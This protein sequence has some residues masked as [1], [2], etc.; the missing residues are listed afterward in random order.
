MKTEFINYRGKEFSDEKILAKLPEDLRVLLQMING[1]IAF[2]GGLHVRGIIDFPEWHSLQKVW[3][4]DFAL[5]KIFL[6]LKESDI[7]F[8]QDCFGDQFILR[9]GTVWQLNA[10]TDELENM[11]FSLNEF[12]ANAEENPV[13][14]LSLQPLV[15]F[16]IEG[17]KIENGQLLNVY[18]PFCTKESAEGVSLKA[19]PMFERISFLADFARQIKSL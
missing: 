1:F 13:D 12:L 19:V 5:Y 16:M 3:F 15:K 4:G 10:E 14:F 7:P 2:D 8:A 6:S 18:P 11:N 17:G 9:D